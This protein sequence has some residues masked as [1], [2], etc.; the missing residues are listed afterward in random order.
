MNDVDSREMGADPGNKGTGVFDSAKWE[1][2]RQQHIDG[3]KASR[4][5]EMSLSQTLMQNHTL[6]TLPQRQVLRRTRQK[7][8]KSPSTINWP[9]STSF[10]Q[11][12]KYIVIV[13]I[14]YCLQ[15]I[16]SHIKP[17]EA[18][19]QVEMDDE[20][21]MFRFEMFQNFTKCLNN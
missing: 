11:F 20:N 21:E 16:E 5:P 10:T 17:N 18:K 13:N 9:T 7:P 12:H 4:W 8:T 15:N 14:C 6:A 1:T 2:L 19:L 3:P